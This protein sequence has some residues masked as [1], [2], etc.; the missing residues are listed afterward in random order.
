MPKFPADPTPYPPFAA[1]EIKLERARGFINELKREL[2]RYRASNPLTPTFETHVTPPQ[3]RIEH[4]AI[5][6]LPGAI[7]G[8]A[9]HNLRT[10]LDLMASEL[11]RIK[12]KS[13]SDVYF[14]FAE[15]EETL[16]AAIKSKCFQKAGEDAVTLLKEI[17]PYRG[18]NDMLRAIHDLD[19]QDKYTALPVTLGHFKVKL[20]ASYNIDVPFENTITITSAEIDYLF[21]EGTVLN[22][23]KCVE[24]LEQLVEIVSRV[25]K[26][27]AGLV[28]ARA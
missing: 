9:I 25:L 24:S 14:P 15:N 4:T 8:D 21:W 10:T 12:F 1:S 20:S 2:E 5:G 3:I 16:E 18:G 22:G 27:F 23:T 6:L 13:D 7:I 26:A 19:I 11:A 17:R 28:A